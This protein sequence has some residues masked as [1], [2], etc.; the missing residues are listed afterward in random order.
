[1]MNGLSAE[2]TERAETPFRLQDVWLVLVRRRW[3]VLGCALLGLGVGFAALQ[4]LPPTYEAST[5]IRVD[6]PSAGLPELALVASLSSSNQ[7]GTDME[8]LRSRMLAESVVDS[9]KLRVQVAKPRLAARHRVIDS[10]HLEAGADTARL[11][12]VRSGGGFHVESLATGETL[13]TVEAGG[14]LRVAGAEIRLA[15]TAVEY[16][17]I[18][19]DLVSLDEAVA[20]LRRQV[21]I[22][23]PSRDANIVMV[24]SRGSDP[25]LASEIPNVLAAGFVAHRQ[26]IQKA[27]A[28]S[29][30]DFLRQQLDTLA[31]QLAMSEEQLRSFREG[32][33]VID[34]Q[35]EGSTQVRRLSEMQANRAALEVE[36]SALA[37]LVEEVRL[38][39]AAD[40][41]DDAA[42][43]RRLLAFPSLLRNQTAAELLRSLASL[44][45]ERASLL[46]RRSARDPDVQIRTARIQE[47]ER[48]LQ[49]TVTTY[50]DGLSRQIVSL[51]QTLRGFERELDA[52][53]AKE[54]QFAR[55]SRQPKVLEEMYGLLQTRLKEAEVAEAVEDPSLRVV[56]RAT[57]PA[58]PVSPNA[59]L[60]LGFALVAGLLLGVG[61]GFVREYTDESIRTRGDAVYATGLPVLGLVPRLKVGANRTWRNRLRRAPALT[62][63]A[64]PRSAG[65]ALAP[66]GTTAGSVAVSPP[67]HTVSALLVEQAG[68]PS[69][70]TDVYE[71]LHTNILFSA[72]DVEFRTLL[73]TSALPGDGKTTNAANLAITL[74]Q[75]GLRVLLV[76]GDL[77]R[78]TVST[79]LGCPR[80]PGLGEVLA[81]TTPIQE[82][83]RS[84][85]VGAG[86][87]LQ[88]L[89]SGAFPANP[90]QM[91]G[92]KRMEHLLAW[93]KTKYD[94]IIID[95]PP[96][97]VVVDAAMLGRYV[98][99]VVLVAR[100]GVTPFGALVYA[101]EQS[102]NAKMPVVG[103]VLNDIDFRKEAS[104]DQ[105]YQWYGY[106]ESYYS[107]TAS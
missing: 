44:E 102:R 76:D 68:R 12:L 28:R 60:I 107:Q 34:L 71:R 35:M 2:S 77:R 82:A 20:S 64:A 21:E 72:P 8:V 106:G 86:E 32:S 41:V 98:D 4:Y 58:R 105:A 69:A 78:G 81:G 70:I 9:L 65:S 59:K 7:I 18:E 25:R 16:D 27:Q 67:R 40:G 99:G 42:P 74:A 85:D 53:P 83:L 49:S 19:L 92:S 89:A 24:R 22:V 95:S 13:G 15:P 80:S 37:Q 75:R 23:R 55:L 62:L 3:I 61:G 90:A 93:L 39:A 54:L 66:V 29:T 6:E 33:Q 10:V 104:Y 84:V 14:L 11:R 87:P 17:E 57:V 101:I 36:R 48:Q 5:S 94:K 51:D 91:L 103:V 38:G 97:N 56:D 46:M 100:T 47:L 96:L 79:L 45:D 31:I 43:Y 50:L 30:A 88:V 73:L 1:M 26:S 52:I 63:P